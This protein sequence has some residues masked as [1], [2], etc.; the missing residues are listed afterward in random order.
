MM[1]KKGFWLTVIAAVAAI[2]AASVAIAAFIKR[3]SE[4]LSDQ[5]DYDPEEYFEADDDFEEDEEPAACCC[6]C[7]SEEEETDCEGC[8]F[9]PE[10]PEEAEEEPKQE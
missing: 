4:A 2:A 3:K 9:T 7:E 8:V 5:L 10:E 6:A 1:K